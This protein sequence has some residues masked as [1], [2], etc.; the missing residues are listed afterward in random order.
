MATTPLGAP[1]SLPARVYA[2]RDGTR[3]QG[4]RRSQ[5]FSGECL[6]PP[7]ISL[8]SIYKS[9]DQ[10]AAV[11][12]ASFDVDEGE[13]F[14]VLGPN[15]AGKTTLIRM[16]IDIIK[17]DSGRILFYGHA[18]ET[19]D[20]DT[21]GYLPEERGLYKKQ[22]VH[23]VLTYFARLKGMD[24]PAARAGVT[25]YLDLLEMADV[26]NKR[27]EDLSKGMQQKI[28]LIAAIIAGPRI[29]ILD[30]PFSGLDPVNLRLV[31]DFIWALKKSGKTVLLST[32]MMVQVEAICDRLFMIYDGRCVLYGP[33]AEIKRQFS[34][35]AILMRAAVDYARIP[36]IGRFTTNGDATKVYLKSGFVPLDLL[37]WLTEQKVEISYF[38]QAYASLEDIFVN[39]VKGKTREP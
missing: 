8:K 35:N 15:G 6:V 13:V 21:I 2:V 18:L 10:K 34:D 29:V 24:G 39:I 11:V 37:Q 4:C 30:E 22:K 17:P 28:Q 31:R 26:R 16:L 14:G 3:R 1:A 25:H 32:H 33:V 12:D 36:M 27:V 38:E 7:V 20:K 19:G 9:F 5:V 23:E